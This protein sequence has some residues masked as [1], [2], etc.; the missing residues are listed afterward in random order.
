MTQTWRIWNQNKQQKITYKRVPFK[1]YSYLDSINVAWIFLHKLRLGSHI[2]GSYSQKT[3]LEALCKLLQCK[4]TPHWTVALVI[5]L[6]PTNWTPGRGLLSWFVSLSPKRLFAR[7][8]QSHQSCSWLT[9]L[10]VLIVVV[11]YC[12]SVT[13]F[14]DS[15]FLLC[16]STLSH[17]NDFQV[18]LPICTYP[19]LHEYRLPTASCFSINLLVVQNFH[20]NPLYRH[21]ENTKKRPQRMLLRYSLSITE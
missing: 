5:A 16:H 19:I 12:S 3:Q 7:Q 15:P 20:L 6:S 11:S 17:N 9:I 14:I 2:L 21:F 1:K 10:L 18:Y 13:H 4:L 8:F